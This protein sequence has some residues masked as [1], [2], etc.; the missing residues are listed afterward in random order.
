M[1]T[2]VGC[3]NVPS[4]VWQLKLCRFFG[5]DRRFPERSRDVLCYVG[6]IRP[7]LGWLPPNLSETFYRLFSNLGETF[8]QLWLKFRSGLPKI[9]QKFGKSLWKVSLKFG[10]SH[11]NSCPKL[12]ATKFGNVSKPKFGP[13]TG[14]TSTCAE[15][16]AKFGPNFIIFTRYMPSFVLTKKYM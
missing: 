9:I 8:G 10:G 15:T 11:T 5:F 14:Q 6:S 12:G 7:R 3:Q 2:F 1:R 13:S 4:T 16:W